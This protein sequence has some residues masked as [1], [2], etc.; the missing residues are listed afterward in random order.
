[1]KTECDYGKDFARANNATEP[2]DIDEILNSSISIPTE[3]Y[4]CMVKNGIDS[5]NSL[6][7]WQG[8]NSAVLTELCSL[9]RKGA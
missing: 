2:V 4:I 5:P 1:M 3:D 7:Y 6:L 9:N 8:Y